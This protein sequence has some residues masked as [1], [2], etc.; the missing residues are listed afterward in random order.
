[1]FNQSIQMSGS[2]YSGWALSDTVVGSS[3]LIAKALD[4]SP[5][6]KKIKNCLKTK[7]AQEISVAGSKLVK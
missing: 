6:S 5:H 3:R 2:V 7:S 1:M 4:C